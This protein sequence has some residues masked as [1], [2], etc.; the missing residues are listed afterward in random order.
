MKIKL[1]LPALLTNKKQEV[2]TEECRSSLVSIDHCL[3]IT[4]DHEPYDKRVAGVW[5]NFLDKWRGKKYDYLFIVANDTIADPNAI[6]YMIRCLEDNPEAGMVTGKVTREIVEFR[7]N[8]GTYKYTSNLTTGLIDPACFV[9]KKGVIEKIGRIDEEFPVEFVE[10][11]YI[12]RLRL[13]GY[14][15]IQP[16][17]TL[18]YHPPFAGTIGNDDNRL[19][20]YLRKYIAKWGGDANMEEYKFPYNDASLDYTHCRK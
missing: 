5:N 18:W 6:D 14:K 3:D 11:D 7:K 10:R 8:E 16:D 1:L 20:F 13:A 2:M 19:R 12:Y 17:I 15:V 4:D 9:F